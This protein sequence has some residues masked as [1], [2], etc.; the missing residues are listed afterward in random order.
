M[1]SVYHNSFINLSAT[2]ASDSSFGLFAPHHPPNT[3]QVA[4]PT[5]SKNYKIETYSVI[6]SDAY[7]RRIEKGIVNTRAWVLQE[8]YIS[9]RNLHFC[10]DQIAWECDTCDALEGCAAHLKPAKLFDSSLTLR[11]KSFGG[12]GRHHLLGELR[13]KPE[14]AYKYEVWYQLLKFYSGLEITKASDRLVA[15]NGVAQIFAARWQDRYL[16]GLWEQDLTYHLLWHF[17]ARD[18]G[19]QILHN[20]R[21]EPSIYPT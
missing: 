21:L 12:S 19:H 7:E 11:F 10:K 20:Q 4:H 8:R 9:A 14:K 17:D 15:L 6:E 1:A 2:S 5:S 16:A 13:H 3:V 18:N